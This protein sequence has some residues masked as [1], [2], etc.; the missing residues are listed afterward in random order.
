MQIWVGGTS[1]LAFEA[2]EFL[3]HALAERRGTILYIGDYDPAGVLID[4]A[5]ETELRRH[6]SDDVELQFYRLA[7]APDQIIAYS[8]PTKPRKPG[9]RRAL[10]V[11]ETVEAEATPAA[12]LRELLRAVIEAHLPAGALKA[13][14]AA[15]QSERE[16]LRRWAEFTASGD[17]P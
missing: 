17:M 1:G 13:V 10:L 14:Q 5:L 15:E 9:E 3:E 16:N 2:A 8:L 11:Q 12:Q 7:I 4:V 6:L